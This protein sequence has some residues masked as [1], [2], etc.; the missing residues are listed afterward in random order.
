MK[1]DPRL[2]S[3]AP[4]SP[5][6]KSLWSIQTWWLN[7]CTLIRSSVAPVIDR[8]RMITLCTAFAG[9][10]VTSSS[11]GSPMFSPP[12]TSRAS[13]PRPTI[14]LSEATSCI[15]SLVPVGSVIVPRTCTTS[16]SGRAM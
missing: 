15:P 13:P 9:G 14:V 16:G 6:E 5:L 12:P 4:S 7:I 10:E 2:M 11:T 3:T 1:S 8:F